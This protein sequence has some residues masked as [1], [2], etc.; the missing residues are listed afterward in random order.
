MVTLTIV[1]AV[2]VAIA[3]QLINA[4]DHFQMGK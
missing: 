4:E 2:I 3:A 1:A